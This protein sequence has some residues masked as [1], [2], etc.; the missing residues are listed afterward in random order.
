[1]PHVDEATAVAARL[2]ALHDEPV[3]PTLGRL[4]ASSSVVTV[5]QTAMPGLLQLAHEARLGATEREGDDAPAA[6]D[7]PPAAC[8]RSR[9]HRSAR[10]ELDARGLRERAS[11]CA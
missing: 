5:T 7:A 8:A 11:R 9:R 6:A 3:G 4:L 10:P 1:M 2:G